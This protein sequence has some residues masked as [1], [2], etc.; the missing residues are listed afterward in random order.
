MIDLEFKH[1]L[2]FCNLDINIDMLIGLDLLNKLNANINIKDM[3]MSFI[4]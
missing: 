2:L 1:S 4:K 3:K